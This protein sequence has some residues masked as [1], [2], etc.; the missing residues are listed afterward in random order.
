MSKREGGALLL[1]LNLDRSLKTDLTQQLYSSLRDLILTGS[2]EA[3]Q[4]IPS[5]RSLSNDHNVSRTIPV[6]ALQRLAAEGLLESRIGAGTY[7]SNNLRLER[8]IQRNFDS[9]KQSQKPAQPKVSQSFK[10]ISEQTTTQLFPPARAF[11]F[12]ILVQRGSHN[13]WQ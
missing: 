11:T 5:S 12:G 3:G 7:V 9:N 4:R 10:K 2:L 6:N 1:S 8:P 13:D